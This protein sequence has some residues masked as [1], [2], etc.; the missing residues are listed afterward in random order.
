[1]QAKRTEQAPSWA[2]DI[3]Q[4]QLDELG[5]EDRWLREIEVGETPPA[6]QISREWSTMT[7]VAARHHCS[8][9]FIRQQRLDG[10]LKARCLNPDAPERQRRY[11]VHRDD[12]LVWTEGRRPRR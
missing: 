3:D 1:M 6:L 5:R 8:A 12:E 2:L 9:K 10:R 4:E 11:V 7:E